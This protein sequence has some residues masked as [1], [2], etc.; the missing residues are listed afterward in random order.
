MLVVPADVQPITPTLA[1]VIVGDGK[2]TRLDSVT[3]QPSPALLALTAHLDA[4]RIETVLL[5]R[6]AAPL[7]AGTPGTESKAATRRHAAFARMGLE[8]LRTRGVLPERKWRYLLL[9]LQ[10]AAVEAA[11]EHER[12]ER[13][14]PPWPVEPTRL[15][16]HVVVRRCW[17]ALYGDTPSLLAAMEPFDGEYQGNVL[18]GTLPKVL[19][20]RLGSERASDYVGQTL[21]LTVT[22]ERNTPYVGRIHRPVAKRKAPPPPAPAIDRLAVARRE[23]NV[24]VQMLS[25]AE[26]RVGYV[27]PRRIDI[28]AAT[29]RKVKV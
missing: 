10:G 4:H 1:R 2:H 3:G 27:H 14:A 15:N 26:R 25:D 23:A 7:A 21:D 19:R 12:A 13:G 5:R 22:V 11:W 17:V 29:A 18:I 8:A 6:W 20:T 24:A 28:A 9:T 16:L